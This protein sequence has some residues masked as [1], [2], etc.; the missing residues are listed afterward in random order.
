MK[1]KELNK[2]L[3]NKLLDL[4]TYMLN[5]SLTLRSRNFIYLMKLYKYKLDNYPKKVLID[6]EIENSH[7]AV[8][9]S[10][11]KRG[12]INNLSFTFSE[13]IFKNINSIRRINHCFS[14]WIPLVI[15]A[16][17]IESRTFSICID[18]SDKGHQG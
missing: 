9:K 2:N 3:K 16:S 5:K 15:K 1:V 17:K 10:I 18:S 6:L 14:F 7:G 12:K 4:F 11:M 8:I 13:S